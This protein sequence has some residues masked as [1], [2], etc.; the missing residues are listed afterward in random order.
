MK[1]N[2]LVTGATG[3]IGKYVVATLLKQG[4]AVIAT[5]A[6]P[7]K[8][9]EADWYKDVTYIPFLLDQWDPATDLFSFFGKPDL[10][11]HLA[12]EGLPN[13]KSSFHIDENLPRHKTFLGNLLSNGLTDLT[14][15]GTC[16][17][18]GMQNGELEESMPSTPANPYAIAK[19]ELRKY[20]ESMQSW[21]SFSFK[22]A[23]LFYMYGIGQN[24]NSLLSQLDKAL[25]NGDPIFNMSGGEQIRDYLAV[26]KVAAGIVQ[27]A[28]QQKVTGIINIA[29]GI[30][31]TVKQ[32]VEDHL[33]EKQAKIFLNLGHYP[34]PDFEPMY[35]W[36]NIKKLKTITVYE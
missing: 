36:A 9:A 24:P 12:W 17:E 7:E 15:V 28:I 32:L 14:V 20:L 33:R 11:I 21:Y 29:S 16:F 27:V 19:D 3:F 5:S 22:W 26:E 30:P 34:Y 18:Y 23:R 4:F 2:V 13:Y 25:Q 10:L 8:A 1:K 35:F 31:V 6:R